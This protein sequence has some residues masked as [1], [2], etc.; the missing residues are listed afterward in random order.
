MLES[1]T[2]WIH[3]GAD[4]L[5][6]NTLKIEPGKDLNTKSLYEIEFETEH[7]VDIA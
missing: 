6:P 4:Y 3:I 2:T 7:T 1:V 5:K